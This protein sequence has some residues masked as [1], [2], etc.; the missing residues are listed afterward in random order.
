MIAQLPTTPLLLIDAASPECFV[1]IWQDQ[2]WLATASPK[3][4][5]L[6][7][8]FAGVDQC[9]RDAT[10]RLDQVRGFIHAEGPGSILGIR[11]SAMAIRT[12]RVLAPWSSAPV[13]AFGHLHFAA[14]ARAAEGH[15][16]PAAVISEFRHG[17]WNCLRA[18]KEHVVAIDG[19]ELQSLPAPV[20]YVPQRKNW[21]KPPPH[22]IEWV[23][24]WE[25]HAAML[26]TQGL[27]RPVDE[28]GV[29]VAEE[30]EFKKWTPQR[31][32]IR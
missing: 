24:H 29:W 9:L 6:E 21:G 14:A 10:L 31:P 18:N 16:R 13:W 32:A 2:T 28:P 12:W 19:D 17:R 5:A 7:G 25:N 27:L 11:L 3:A 4:P 15:E 8:I 22:A 1:G 30:A 26:G 23:P 20:I